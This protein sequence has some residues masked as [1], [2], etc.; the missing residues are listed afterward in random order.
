MFCISGSINTRHP[1]ILWQ[2]H[3]IIH[4]PPLRMTFVESFKSLWINIAG[5]VSCVAE[6]GR[7]CSMCQQCCCLRYGGST[8]QVVRVS[9][10]PG[11]CHGSPY[12]SSDMATYRSY[13]KGAWV[14][15]KAVENA[16]LHSYSA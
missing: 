1:Y 7:S 16:S 10:L 11:I 14:L 15:R 8:L 3:C 2:G 12:M 13:V 4:N 6:T 9:S 5:E